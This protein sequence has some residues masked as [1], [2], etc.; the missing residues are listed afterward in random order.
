MA[1]I[2]PQACLFNPLDDGMALLDWGSAE[3]G[4]DGIASLFQSA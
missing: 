4:G 2:L 1:M 3:A